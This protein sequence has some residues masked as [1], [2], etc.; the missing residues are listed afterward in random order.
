VALQSVPSLIYLGP[1]IS[2]Q[3]MCNLQITLYFPLAGYVATFFG[4]CPL[5]NKLCT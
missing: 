5:V 2:M 1:P 4:V 3:S